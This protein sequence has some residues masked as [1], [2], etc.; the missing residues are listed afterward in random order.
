MS[1]AGEELPEPAKYDPDAVATFTRGQ[2]SDATKSGYLNDSQEKQREA[3]VRTGLY[4]PDGK[5]P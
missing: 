5:R 1:V 3:I 4:A 2:T